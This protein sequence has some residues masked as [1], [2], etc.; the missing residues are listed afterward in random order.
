MKSP[1][2]RI[3]TKGS[4]GV[5]DVFGCGLRKER[6]KPAN[7]SCAERL[8]RITGKSPSAVSHRAMVGKDARAGRTLHR[9]DDTVPAIRNANDDDSRATA[10]LQRFL[11]KSQ[12]RSLSLSCVLPGSKA[13]SKCLATGTPLRDCLK[14]T[15][16]IPPKQCFMCLNRTRLLQRYPSSSLK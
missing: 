6:T 13:K 1:G 15:L 5:C 4:V 9:S 7:L 10:S 8:R 2:C 3:K 16:Y 11:W 12:T 14:G